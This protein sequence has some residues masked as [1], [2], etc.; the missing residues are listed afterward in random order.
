MKI[1]NHAGD[2]IY[3]EKR[4]EHR[5]FHSDYNMLCNPELRKSA[6][7]QPNCCH[8]KDQTCIQIFFKKTK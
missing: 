8:Y 1:C 7:L 6:G 3:H 5:V 2:C 4:C